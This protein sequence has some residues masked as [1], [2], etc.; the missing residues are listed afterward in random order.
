MLPVV[1]SL[2]SFTYFLDNTDEARSL[3]EQRLT[4]EAKKRAQAELKVKQQQEEEE[5]QR[6]LS[7]AKAEAEAKPGMRWNKELREYEYIK[8][9]EEESWR[10]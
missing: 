10:D 4:D 8:N 6:I 1:R 9:T 3:H 7:D 2:E 5:R